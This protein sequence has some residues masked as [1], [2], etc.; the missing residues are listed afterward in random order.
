V[1]LE[2]Q[3]DAHLVTVFPNVIE[4]DDVRMVDQFEDSHFTLDC[5]GHAPYSF[6]LVRQITVNLVESGKTA[7]LGDVSSPLGDNLDRN[8]LFR[9]T[10]SGSPDSS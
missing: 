6:N 10:M 7:S 9:N 1:E 8:R 4:F 3:D 2:A 5:E